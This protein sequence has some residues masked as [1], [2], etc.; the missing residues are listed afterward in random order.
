M[1]IS[2]SES[3]G[4]Y[5]HSYT[6]NDGTIQE[7]ILAS[8]RSQ[9]ASGK[10]K[11]KKPSLFQIFGLER[12]S[13]SSINA[14][15]P[16][17]RSLSESI[18]SNGMDILTTDP[19]KIETL[20]LETALRT[21][22]DLSYEGEISKRGNKGFRRWRLRYA[23]LRGSK[24]V[25]Y[26]TSDM[27]KIRKQYEIS[28]ETRVMTD[29]SLTHP[30]AFCVDL[31]KS[32][33]EKILLDVSTMRERDVW[34]KV[35][36][37]SAALARRLSLSRPVVSPFSKSLTHSLTNTL[38]DSIT[39]SLSPTVT[40][41]DLYDYHSSLGQ[42]RYGVV[43]LVGDKM[44]GSL[45]AVKSINKSKMS[46]D[47]LDSEIRLLN[48]IR[49]TQSNQQTMVKIHQIINES[50]VVHIIM[51]YLGGGDLFSRI[52]QY[53]SLSEEESASIIRQ[54]LTALH[55][56]HFASILHCDVKPENIIFES[57]DICSSAKLADFGCCYDMSDK[58]KKMNYVVGT[59]GYI[60]PEVITKCSYSVK[61]DVYSL[62]VTLFVMLTGTHPFT[63]CCGQEILEQTVN[64][65]IVYDPLI[66]S[67]LSTSAH[68]IL[69]RM[70]TKDPSERLSV[71]ELLSEE[72]VL[73]PPVNHRAPRLNKPKESLSMRMKP[74]QLPYSE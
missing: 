2:D 38:P 5:V 33:K 30:F 34:M 21:L 47:V 19:K 63:G 48:R 31:K 37:F 72:W 39:H 25:L 40:F 7:E 56:L 6:A 49:S 41:N 36:R 13:D 1:S 51:E 18:V 35:L 22:L 16:T 9:S 57:N 15:K 73:N 71:E 65:D 26:E 17:K 3:A 12:G 24:F 52:E 29:E 69:Q 61:S 70:L 50:T 46:A 67:H 28:T 27:Q 54:I 8:T 64:R 58:S 4:C 59:P 66:W 74:I 20:D 23:C 11:G 14:V 68:S 53:G 44:N 55:S 42:G 62:G 45:F 43:S 10:A 32:G 60:A